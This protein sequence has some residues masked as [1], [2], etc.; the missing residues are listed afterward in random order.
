MVPAWSLQPLVENAIK[1]AV[2]ARIDG[3]T[4][5][6]EAHR[7]GES[8]AVR[9]RDDGDGFAPAWKDGTGLGSLRERLTSLFGD[10]ATLVVENN[11]GGQVTMTLPVRLE[12]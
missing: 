6:I 1:Y 2:A 5:A 11:H 9:V 7:S 4:V 8:L 3:G 10:R 12:T